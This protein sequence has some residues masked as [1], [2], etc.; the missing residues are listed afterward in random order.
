M[1]TDTSY[2][3]LRGLTYWARVTVPRTRRKVVGS[4]H[5]RLSLQT[6]DLAEANRRKFKAVAELKRVIA[7][8]GIGD[9]GVEGWR[10]SMRDAV[11]SNNEDQ[12]Y[13]IHSLA[14]DWATAQIPKIGEDAASTLFKKA[15]ETRDSLSELTA[16]YIANGGFG[17]DATRKHSKALKD[18]VIFMRHDHPPILYADRELLA[19]TDSVVNGPLAPNTKRDRLSS[20]G[21]FWRWLEQRLHAPKGSNPFTGITVRG[22]T[23]DDVRAF[24]PAEVVH[25]LNSTFSNE[26]QKDIFK[27]LLL[28]GARPNE[29]CSLRHCDIDTKAKT[30]TISDSKTDA[31]VRTLPYRHPVL[32]AIFNKYSK[33]SEGNAF[34]FPVGIDPNG[35]QAKNFINYF[36]RHKR[37]IN[38]DDGVSLYSTRK[39]FIGIA[40]DL[41]LDIVNVERY[42]GHKNQRLALSVYSKGRS[43][44]GLIKIAE[45]IASGWK[46]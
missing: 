34:V 23:V 14:E 31:G 30:F 10:S 6:R 26:W 40:L 27:V 33:T 8:A 37:R 4:T 21:G 39:T 9:S 42:V 46:V 41:S 18:F 7:E 36:S 13:L 29:V 17:L 24:N 2:L 22:G 28:T 5:L 32:A 45:G 25:V 3:Q 43:D 38:L 15:I 35:K 20:L 44:D 1:T 11:E 19:F 12:A 16:Q